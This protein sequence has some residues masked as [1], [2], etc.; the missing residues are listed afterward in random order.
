MRKC[1]DLLREASAVDPQKT[2]KVFWGFFLP[3]SLCAAQR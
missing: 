1:K 2:Y 3:F